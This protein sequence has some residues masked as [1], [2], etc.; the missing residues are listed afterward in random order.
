M[1]RNE[2]MSMITTEMVVASKVGN[3]VHGPGIKT[4]GEG[5]PW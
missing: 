3:P 1:A 2:L 5:L 4:K